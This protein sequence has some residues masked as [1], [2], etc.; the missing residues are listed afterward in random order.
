MSQDTREE[1][2]PIAGFPNYQVSN[3]GN[4]MN[5][6][7]GR[8]IKNSI[9]CNGYMSVNLWKNNKLK[10]FRVHILVAQAFLPNP[11]NLP[12]VNHIDECKT[13]NDANNLEWCTASQNIR[14]SIYRQYRK[15]NQ[16]SLDGEFIKQWESISQI[17]KKLGIGNS[18]II[19]CCKGERKQ[20]YGYK[21]QY[22]DGLNQQRSKRPVAAF[23][24][25]GE[26]V[27]KYKSAAEASRCLNICVQSIID[28]LNGNYKS[29]HGFMFIDI[30]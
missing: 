17:V 27:A 26:F 7:T 3:K 23:T 11:L 22:A 20:A 6:K 10:H 4:V 12:Q 29:T 14:Y 5:L 19:Q 25:E 9:D 8:V 15:I 21:W 28:C 18:H 2:R 30:D 13:N 1:W 16:L 24:K